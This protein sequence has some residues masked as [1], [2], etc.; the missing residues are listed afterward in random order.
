M[1]LQFGTRESTRDVDAIILSPPD[2]LGVRAL[3]KA[4]ADERGWPEDWLNDAVK[5]F[6][7]SVEPGSVIFSAA[8]ITVRQPPLEQMLAMKICAWRDDVDVAD[9][10]HLLA[11]ISGSRDEIW[12]RVQPI[13]SPAAS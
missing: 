7:T 6:V 9:A 5:G 3:S 10:R 13:F 11:M 8:G 1:V 12:E 2:L 4:V